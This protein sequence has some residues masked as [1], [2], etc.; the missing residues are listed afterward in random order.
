[1]M[2][3]KYD[4]HKVMDNI[5]K[6][7]EEKGLKNSDVEE[8]CGLSKGY[9]SR[10][11]KKDADAA[12]PIDIIAKI[13][14]FLETSIDMMIYG[15]LSGTKDNIHM[16]SN[17]LTKLR[18]QTEDGTQIWHAI[19]K[20]RIDAMI[21]GDEEAIFIIGKRAITDP[22]EYGPGLFLK[23][24]TTPHDP[25]W[26]LG[27]AFMT[28]IAKDRRLYIFHF[29]TDLKDDEHALP[30]TDYFELWLESFVPE[31]G[32]AAVA[33][34]LAGER[35]GKW[36]AKPMLN[37]L[38]IGQELHD[39]AALLYRCIERKEY[40]LKIESDVMNTIRAYMNR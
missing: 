3:Q 27:D 4:N 12:P 10:Q 20:K 6:L 22:Q 23:S 37:T 33:A 28:D 31:S 2:V 19:T 1:M 5:A 40:D 21:E 24:A 30:E 8:A 15:D 38:N 17:F 39:D 25:T 18:S 32:V 13:A 26:L 35:T 36:V 7:I 9:L 29:G 16:M 14:A 34:A 11:L